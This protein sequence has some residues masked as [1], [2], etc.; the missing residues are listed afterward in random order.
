M[1][2]LDFITSLHEQLKRLPKDDVEERLRFYSE[3]IEDRMEE[4]LS[5]E[6]AVAAIG[7]LDEVVSQIINDTPFTKIAK[8][9]IQSKRS[10]NAWEIVLLALGF[11]IW[12]PLL[13]AAFAIVFSLYISFW[14][15]IISLWAVFASAAVCAPASI[16]S[17]IVFIT[18]GH[19]PSGIAMIGA[20]ITCAGLAIF[21][22]F[23]CK[24][25]TNG[26]IL[27]T[28]KMVLGIKKCFIKK[29]EAICEEA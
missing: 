3:M 22:F 15:L 13:I 29:E 2:K 1:T 5:E 24:A 19:I 23:G 28:R 21:L 16:L 25:A 6:E 27:L 12:A 7:P 26:T 20:G 8:A 17:G 4:G 10:L 11:P 9:K 14:S 18:S